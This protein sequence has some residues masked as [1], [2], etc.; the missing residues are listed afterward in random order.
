MSNKTLLR[1]ITRNMEHL[2]QSVYNIGEGNELRFQRSNY[3]QRHRTLCHLER[4]YSEII[5]VKEA[6]ITTRNSCKYCQNKGFD[7]SR[8]E[9]RYNF[10]GPCQ[11]SHVASRPNIWFGVVA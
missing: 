2:Q 11:G 9:G 5:Q 10:C 1:H 8:D 7:S 3:N 6:L 4:R